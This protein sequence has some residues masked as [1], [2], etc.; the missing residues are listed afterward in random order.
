MAE[1]FKSRRCKEYPVRGDN[2]IEGTTSSLIS[3]IIEGHH[4]RVLIVITDAQP[5]TP[6]HSPGAGHSIKSRGGD[7]ND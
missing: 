3:Q 2:N 7:K 1:K 5:T 6:G 4:D